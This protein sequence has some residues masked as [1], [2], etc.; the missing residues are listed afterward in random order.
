MNRDNTLKVKGFDMAIMQIVKECKNVRYI[1]KLEGLGYIVNMRPH[2]KPR[3][4][5]IYLVLNTGSP[6]YRY[7]IAFY[8]LIAI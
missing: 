8:R 5:N 1:Q 4:P 7:Y 3:K 6:S 2:Y